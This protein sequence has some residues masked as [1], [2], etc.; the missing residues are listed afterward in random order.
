MLVYPRLV[1]LDRLF[2]ESGT[3]ALDGRRLLLRRPSGFE[4]HGV[5]EHEEGE[6]LRRVHWPSTAKRGELMVKELED[7]PRDEVAIVLDAARAGQPPGR[8]STCRCAPRGRSCTPMPPRAAGGARPQRERPRTSAWSRR[9]TGGG[10]RALAAVEPGAR[11]PAA[12]LLAD[13]GGRRARRASS[14]Q[15]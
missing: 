8:A 5:R 14:W 15:S 6:S 4:L 2:S 9:A 7:A 10:V 12:A 3:G 13:E 11:A 1:E